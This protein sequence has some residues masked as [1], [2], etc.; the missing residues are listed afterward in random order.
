MDYF[1]RKRQDVIME[2]YLLGTDIGTGS[3]KTVALSFSG[4]ILH[5][6]QHSYSTHHPRPEYSEQ[7]PTDILDAFIQAVSGTVE[8]MGHPPSGISFSAVM[9]SLLAVDQKGQPLTPLLI[10]SDARSRLIADE[11]RSTPEARAIYEATGTPLHSMSPLCKIIWIRKFQPGI[12]ASTYKFI[13]IKEYVWNWLFETFQVDHSLA[14][15]TGLF[16]IDSLAWHSASLSLAGINQGHLSQPVPTSFVQTGLKEATASLLKIPSHTPFCI[17]ASDGC[18]A[19]LGTHSLGGGSAA[20]TIGTSGAVRV[21][22]PIPIRN[23]E[24]MSFNYILD[25]KTFICGGPTNNGGNIIQ[26]LQEK[27]LERPY[28]QGADYTQ[29][30]SSVEHTPPGAEGLVFLPYIHG[31]RAPVWDE[32]SSGVFLGI[33]PCHTQAHFL[34]AA[35][36]GVCFGLK[37]ILES[38]ET[39]SQTISQI[40]ASGGFVHSAS[41]V[42]ILADITGKKVLVGQQE[43]ASATGAALLGLTALQLSNPDNSPPTNGPF[44]MPRQEYAEVY[45]LGFEVYR[46]IYPLLK[47]SMHL[48]DTM[49]VEPE[50]R[51]R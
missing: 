44:I 25:E 14:S 43:D 31:E 19:N 41:W 6:G 36:E 45:R 47:D 22:S 17:G 34:R 2:P 42:Q 33:K 12:F 26:W 48:L 50:K 23:F 18:L 21:A 13:S 15:A 29:L 11:I 24:R 28:T 27:F 16:N 3:T 20:I 39:R 35:L 32:E 1:H 7:D 8:A 9:H 40:N 51:P 37:Q 5:T 10:W 49:A 4:K 30:F 38:M 46:S